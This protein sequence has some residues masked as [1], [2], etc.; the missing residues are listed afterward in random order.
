MK[1]KIFL[2]SGDPV[3]TREALILL[4][5]LDGQTTNPSLIAKNPDA[6]ARLESGN[7]F[8]K[9]EINLF[10]KKVISEIAGLV[11]GGAIS[12]EVYADA[13]TSADAIVEQAHAMNSWCENAYIK[14][15]IT[16]NGLEAARV[17]S[18]EGIQLNMTLCF[19]QEQAAAVY[20]ATK[21]SKKGQIFVSPFIGRLDDIGQN[22]ADLIGN[23]LNMYR[24]GDGHVEVLAASIRNLEHMLV[25]V[26]LNVDIITAPL[27]VYNAWVEDGKKIPDSDYKLSNGFT[28]IEY[29]NL[30]LNKEWQE[31]NIQH[32]L[33]DKGLEKFVGDWN[34]LI[35]G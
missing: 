1:T 29:N 10:Y 32:D 6:R 31:Y 12:V 26:A 20:V 18:A 23:I 11:P 28:P 25:C 27:K 15:P 4:G 24:V 17:L 9:E 2:D 7:K 30:D 21:G 8:S 14:I 33:T 35:V 13:N 3:E 5:A 16:K 19:S 34:S 22:G